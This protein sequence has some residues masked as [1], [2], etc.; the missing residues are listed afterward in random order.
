[1]STTSK[2]FKEVILKV[3]QRHIEERGLFNASQF[4]FH[5]YH[6][7]TLQCMRLMEHVTLNFNN[8][9]STAAVFSDIEKALDITWHLGLLYKLSELKFLIS[10][11]KFISSFLYQGKLRVLVE[12][13]MS[14]PRDIEAGV[15]QGSILSPTLYSIYEND[16]LQTPTVYLGLSADDTFI[17][18]QTAKRVMFSESC[19][20]VLVLL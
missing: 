20:K 10:L 9:I 11:I 17:M 5:A 3:V 7:M 16:M 4:G 2:I 8:N 15:P 6:S 19:S 14:E 12:G 1:L 13:E 18:L